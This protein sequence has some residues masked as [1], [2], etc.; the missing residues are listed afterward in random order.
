MTLP[1]IWPE[2]WGSLGGYFEVLNIRELIKF[3]QLK[4]IENNPYTL[5]HK[6]IKLGDEKASKFYVQIIVRLPSLTSSKHR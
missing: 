2:K 4:N 3:M 6:N 1:K 5:E